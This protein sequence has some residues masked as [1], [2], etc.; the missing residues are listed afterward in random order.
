MNGLANSLSSLVVLHISL[1]MT[2][3]I[4][5]LGASLTLRLVIGL[6][7]S[8]HGLQGTSVLSCLAFSSEKATASLADEELISSVKG[9]KGNVSGS[10]V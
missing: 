5:L 3:S 1:W 9:R 2:L 10:R 8:V 6:G 4:S 7:V